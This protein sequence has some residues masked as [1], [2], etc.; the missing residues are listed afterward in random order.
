M[1]LAN[2]N[3]GTCSRC[4]DCARMD[5]WEGWIWEGGLVL[6]GDLDTVDSNP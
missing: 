5:C 6:E 2:D 4:L 1:F 3:E